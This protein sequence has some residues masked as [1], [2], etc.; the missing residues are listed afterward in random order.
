MAYNIDTNVEVITKLYRAMQAKLYGYLVTATLDAAK[1]EWNIKRANIIMEQIRGELEALHAD[2][3]KIDNAQLPRAFDAGSQQAVDALD[4]IGATVKSLPDDWLKMNT[5]TIESLARDMAGQRGLFLGTIPGK[6]GKPYPGSVLRGVDDYLRTLQTNTL[7][8]GAAIGRGSRASGGALRTSAVE[9][10]KQ[11]QALQNLTQQI[12]KAC[13]VAYL[14]DEGKEVAYHSLEF[15]GQMAARTGNARMLEEGNVAAQQELGCELFEVS[16]HGTLCYICRPFEGKVFRYANATSQDAL[17]YPTCP[18]EVPFHPNCMHSRQPWVVEIFGD[19]IPTEEEMKVLSSSNAD[20]YQHMTDQPQ[21]RM[22]MKAAKQGY[23][24]DK[25]FFKDLNA[26]KKRM[27]GASDEEI[28]KAQ[29]DLRGPRWKMKGIEKRRLEATQMM[30]DNPGMTY[31]QAIGK[32]TQKYMRDTE[33]RIVENSRNR[34][35]K[36]IENDIKKLNIEHSYIID[37]EGIVL[38][39]SIG[40]KNIVNTGLD[41]L[42]KKNIIEPY[43]LIQ[44]HNHPLKTF[45][46]KYDVMHGINYKLKEVRI[47]INNERHVVSPING[48]W[49]TGGEFLDIFNFVEKS[50]I[51]EVNNELKYKNLPDKKR[52]GITN[53]EISKRIW[54]NKKITSIVN[55]TIEELKL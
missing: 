54:K 11:N 1:N 18:R 42:H 41:Q 8:E 6:N 47:I 28:L 55:Y 49:P 37:N 40:D 24:S 16:K 51:S 34:S 44:I 7:I 33:Q 26:M 12:D 32:V 23:S 52:S 39:H 22:L 4:K 30:L 19:A 17:K 25:N 45:A 29:R 13:G 2:V 36:K 15:Y 50:K 14:N 5:A 35:I 21:G 27:P 48:A 43:S 53:I 9:A 20:L 38:F 46:S 10:L 31:P 3:S